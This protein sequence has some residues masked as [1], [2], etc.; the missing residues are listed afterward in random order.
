M[1]NTAAARE[2]TGVIIVANIELKHKVERG[3]RIH[4]KTSIDLQ[5]ITIRV[6]VF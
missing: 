6:V 4:V 3:R 5:I 2:R 1:A